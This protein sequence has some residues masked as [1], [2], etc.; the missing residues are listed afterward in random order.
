MN[1][2]LDLRCGARYT[3]HMKRSAI[4]I[5]TIFVV[6][7]LAAIAILVLWIVWS[8]Q[9]DTNA[10]WL[11]QGIILMIPVIV[12]STLIFVYWSKLRLLDAER[13]NFISGISHELLTPLASFRMYVETL[14][15]RRLT[16]EQRQEFL[17]IML[18]ESDRLTHTI[19]GILNVSRIERGKDLYHFVQ[20][21]VADII[22]QFMA[23]NQRLLQHA[24]VTLDCDPD[25]ETR[26]DPDALHVVL[27]NLTEN[28]VRYSPSAAHIT[29]SL[30]AEKSRLILCVE[31]KGDGVEPGKLKSIFKMFT[32]GTSSHPGTGIGL[33]MVKKIIKAHKGRVW[34]E[35]KGKGQGTR[36]MITMP[37]T[38]KKE[39]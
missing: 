39:A 28:A 26:L 21:N 15:M 33:Y 17:Q 19:S 23:E 34:A 1:G 5:I 12:G 11:I 37:L 38:G 14:Q 7:Q 10:W 8:A 18:D 31:D 30:K 13:V 20:A 3:C 6:C 9:A 36:I 2:A 35:S 16:D 22:E 24:D 4:A 32:R 29:I 25:I 27:R